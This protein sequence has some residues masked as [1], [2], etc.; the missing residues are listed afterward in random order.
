MLLDLLQFK[1]INV[2]WWQKVVS[3]FKKKIIKLEII[4]GVLN[5]NNL[6]SQS[7]KPFDTAQLT[8]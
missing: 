3:V 2:K 7:I 6:P 5:R 8:Q 4:P 1:I